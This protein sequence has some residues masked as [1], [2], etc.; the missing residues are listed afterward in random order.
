MST[1]I[2][3]PWAKDIEPHFQ[4]YIPSMLNILTPSKKQ[5]RCIEKKYTNRYN[6]HRDAIIAN[7]FFEAE[8][9]IFELLWQAK[10]GD[11]N[12]LAFLRFIEKICSSLISKLEI[13]QINKL[14]QT[15][16]QAVINFE[17]SKSKYLCY[18]G[19]LASLERILSRNEH[20]LIDVE[21]KIPNGK[22]FDFAIEINKLSVRC[23]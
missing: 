5:I 20:K 13:V 22:C 11:I 15:C 19:E 6:M 9:T 17:R 16:Y 12:S 7:G 3:F 4:F 10:E 23:L 2:K 14:R 8:T 1:E 18:I 21:Y